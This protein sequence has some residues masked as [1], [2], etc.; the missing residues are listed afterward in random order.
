M[1]DGLI[2]VGCSFVGCFVDCVGCFVPLGCYVTFPIEFGL[3]LMVFVVVLW[4]VWVTWRFGIHAFGC[5][6]AL[7]I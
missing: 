3:R 4:L 5:D 2:A 7:E 1:F 6:L